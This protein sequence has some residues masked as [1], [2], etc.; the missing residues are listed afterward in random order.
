MTNE[1]ILR[2]YESVHGFVSRVCFKN[3]PP[4]QVGAELEWLV[5]PVDDPSSPVP[6]DRLQHL[7]TQAAPL[8]AASR[9]TL[10]PGG[11]VEL[12]S[13]PAPS[14]D[15]CCD[16]LRV[17]LAELTRMLGSVGLQRACAAVDPLRAPRR[18]LL[19]PRYD[20]MQAYFDRRGTRV[21]R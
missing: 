12:S 14:L 20:A 11:Q 21:W 10:E 5:T 15:Q 16:D 4:H 7:L 9:I 19:T 2:D 13:Q 8:P 3:G 17:D 6:L 18:V 1:R